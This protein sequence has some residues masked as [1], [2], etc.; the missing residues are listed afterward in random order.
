VA[1]SNEV[2]LV[3]D[4]HAQVG[5]GPVWD[6]R[7]RKLVWLDIMSSQVRRFDPASGQDEVIDVGQHV[8]AV[9]MRESGGMVMA[10]RD[11]F[12]VLDLPS[13]T[14]EM[15]DHTGGDDPESRFNDG[16]CDR[17]GR[18]WAGTMAYDWQTRRGGSALYRL[19]PGFRVQKMLDGVSVSNGLDWSPDDRLM[20][21]IDSPTLQ[22]GVFDY[23]AASGAIENR[24][25]LITLPEGLGF[26]DGMTVDSEGCIWLAVFGGGVVRRYS[27]DGSLD[28]ELR[29]P[30]RQVTSVA[31]GGDDLGDLYITCAAAWL[32][33]EALS[34]QPHAGGLFRHRPDVK[35][36]PANT[37]KG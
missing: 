7:E 27:P 10:M 8:G 12:G 23:D 29:M 4:A 26:P 6:P 30:A 1:E 20:Y 21:Y 25:A 15:V 37:F 19:D 24:R 14:V 35:G 17:A 33:D 9:A 2:E 34:E 31:F 13:G 28:R 3:V 18:F 16:K 36:L 32:S 22:I 11:G 5:E